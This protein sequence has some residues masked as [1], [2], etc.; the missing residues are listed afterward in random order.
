[1]KVET[2]ALV[3]LKKRLRNMNMLTRI[4]E[5]AAVERRLRTGIRG[6][7]LVSLDEK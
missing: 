4:A 2:S 1:M 7:S 5:G 3:T 6:E